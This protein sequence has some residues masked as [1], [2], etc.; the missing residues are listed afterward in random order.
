MAFDPTTARPITAGGFDPNTAQVVPQRPRRKPGATGLAAIGQTFQTLTTGKADHEPNFIERGIMDLS[1]SPVVKT[2][3]GSFKGAVAS[4]LLAQPVRGAMQGLGIGMDELKQKYPGRSEAWYKKALNESYNEAIRDTR[5]EAAAE[6]QS[7]KPKGPG[8]TAA[9]VG[10]GAIDVASNVVANP[11]YFLIPGLGFGGNAA[12]RV[13][14]TIAAEGAVGSVTD[15]AAQLMDIA[16]ETKKDFDVQQNLENTILSAGFGGAA[17]GA[18]EIA[19]FVK[20]M[21]KTRGRDTMPSVDPR[22]SDTQ[23]MTGDR[24]VFTPEEQV[25]LKTALS[26]GSVDDIQAI[27]SRKQGPTPT[28]Q[29]VNAL[30][31]FRNSLPEKFVGKQALDEAVVRQQSDSARL[32][33]ENHITQTMSAWKNAPTV[34]VHATPHEI[35]DEAIRAQ[36][37]AD[38]PD[39]NALGFLGSDGKIRVFSDRIPDAETANAVLFHEGLGHYGL[40]EKFGARLDQTIFSMLERNVSQFARDTDA[41]MKKNPG[42]YG[43]DRVRAAEEVLAEASQNGTIKKSW[44]A[45]L[46]SSIRQFGRKMGL[47]LAYSDMEVRH[48]LSMAHDAVINGKPS[49]AANGFRGAIADQENP[50]R[51]M[52]TGPRAAEFDPTSATLF[53]GKDGDLRNEISDAEA[54]V[55]DVQPGRYRL[56]DVLD[57]PELYR[58]YPE[59]KDMKVIVYPEGRLSESGH[60]AYYEPETR[61]ILIEQG[62]SKDIILHEVQHGIQQIEKRITTDEQGSETMSDEEYFADPREIEAIDTADR[63]NMNLDERIESPPTWADETPRNALNEELTDPSLLDNVDRLKADPRFWSD[64]EFRSNVIELARTRNAPE[65]G[66]QYVPPVKMRTETEYRAE[67]EPELVYMK[68]SQLAAAEDYKAKDLE[69]I[70][71]SLD[72]GYVPTQRSWAEDRRAAL[73]AGFKPSQIKDLKEHKAGDLSTRL[74]RMQAAANMADIKLQALHAK[75]DTPEWSMADQ[76]AYI[77]TIADRNYLVARI[78]GER[79]E[80][81]RALNAS[82][83]ASSYNVSTMNEVAQRLAEAESGLAE[84]ATDPNKFMKFAQSIKTLMGQ[85]NPKGA[86]AVMAGVNKPYWEQYLTSFHY[87]AMLSGL[88]THVKAPL[89]MMIGIQHNLIDN[90]LAMPIGKAYNFVE[91]LTGKPIKPGVSMDEVAARLGGTVRAVFDHEIYRKT[92]EAAKTGEGGAQLPGGTY[93]PTSASQSFSGT[94]NPRMGILSKPTDLIVAEDT[95]FRSVAMA[96][97]LYG[98]G[99]REARARL[100]AAGQPFTR[101][102]VQVLGASLAQNPTSAMLKEAQESTERALLLNAN[103]LTNWIDKVKQVRPNATAGERVSS[104]LANNLAPFVRVAANSLLTR[105]LARSPAALLSPQILKTIA[106]GGPDAHTAVA[107]IAYGTV[108]LGMY[109][110]AADMVTGHGPDNLFKKKELEASGWRQDAVLKDGKYETG[111][112]LAASLNPFDQHNTTAQAVAGLRKAYEKGANEGRV[113]VGLKL[114]LGSILNY[115][116]SQSWVDSI[117]PAVAAA[118]ADGPTGYKVN[119]FASAQAKSWVPAL[120]G[121]AARITNPNRVDMRP[122]TTE[123]DPTNITGAIV[124]GVM[125]SIPGLNDRLPT[126]HSVYGNPMPTGQSVIGARTGI[127]GLDGNAVPQ[128]TD[129]TELE[130]ARLSSLIEGALITPVQRT[131]TVDGEDR[132]LTTAEFQEYQRIAGRAIVLTVQDLIST[133]EWQSMSDQERILEVRDIQKDMK[134][135]VREELFSE[136]SDEEDEATED[137]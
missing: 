55:K 17:R 123:F 92:L 90:A 37:L 18:I 108:L 132:K 128:T 28:Y 25:E 62:A 60:D 122:D 136:P 22:G 59:L 29:D 1:N 100:K 20:D 106:K 67:R 85:N 44:Q 82:K 137:E 49:V 112:T 77:Q 68:K 69:G 70:Y 32:A 79:S 91:S 78:K 42:A 10:L 52:F 48:V 50:N 75:L 71:K 133:P 120:A 93:I 66:S 57:H 3:R 61:S 6:V 99:A 126:Q 110:Q 76:A 7:A 98:L 116:V 101:D 43:G 73:E 26:T 40:A 33:A 103:P 124:N 104:W 64:P 63:T 14:S 36:A 8:N 125:S 74:Y 5:Q 15:A 11:H 46:T 86:H 95:F 34:D 9:K 39:G 115:M 130:L 81:A 23:P 105:T 72:E 38:D 129:E 127:P 118:T 31:E 84:L 41:W 58:N 117:N 19:P 30:V 131:V 96:E 121:Q 87:N 80:I 107:R 65:I 109:W 53:R 114:A 35:P 97:T 119:Q 111:G 16:T 89:D 47:D 45:A 135:A 83:A 21:F 27:L 94:R 102:D 24:P 56:A 2:A 88:G 13:G 51:F 54:T 113:G 12:T 134:K 4:G